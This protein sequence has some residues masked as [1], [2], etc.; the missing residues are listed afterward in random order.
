VARRPDVAT[1][2]YT[3]VTPWLEVVIP[4]RNE[5]RRLPAGLAALNAALA[6]LPLDVGVVVVDSASTDGTCEVVRRHATTGGVPT[7]LVRCERPG[8]GAAVRAGLLATT[9]PYVGFC[10]ADMATDPAAIAMAVRL[11]QTGNPVV[12]GSRSHPESVV[13]DR[14]TV[15]R[16]A[17]AA[18]F[19]A[20]TRV[21]VPGIGDTQCGF[22]FFDGPTARAAA[23]SL[24]LTGFAFDVELIARCVRLGATPIEIPVRWRD[25][26]GSTFSIW[27][28]S[29]S[30][31]AGLGVAWWVL[32]AGAAGPAARSMLGAEASALAAHG[33]MLA[34]D[35]SGLG[36]DAAAVSPGLDAD[37]AAVPSRLG[38]DG[39]AAAVAR[40][41][42]PP[43]AGQS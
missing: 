28:H 7:R 22:K 40:G 23:A 42:L 11:L 36:A 10:D 24:R 27:R 33:S 37:A 19:R 8:K 5:E 9:A 21:V 1:W 18:V 25:V 4:A 41:S 16:K 2:D 13:E 26:S 20:A 15:I 39:A 32:R 43:P 12:L 29:A 14:H 3:P 17:G 38:A 35:A 34:A 6:A 31:F 30:S